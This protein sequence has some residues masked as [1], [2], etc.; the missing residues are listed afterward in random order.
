MNKIPSTVAKRLETAVPKFQK[1]L[2]EA[3]ERDVNESDTVTI[4]KDILQEV[5]GYD[6][7]SEITSEYAIQGTYCDLAVVADKRVEYL[8][9]VKAIGLELNDKHIKQAVNYASGEGIR[10][11]VLTNGIKWE[12]YRVS[13]DK[14]VS[15]EKLFYFDMVEMNPKSKEQQDLLFLLC[16][17]GI[18]KNLIGDYYT[19]KQSVNR[20]T[21]GALLL[22]NKI[23]TAVR[24]ELRKLNPNIKAD[25]EEI[26]S[27]IENEIV[28]REIHE[29]E[30]G[31][32]ANKLIVRFIKKQE[33]ER[34]KA[35]T[36]PAAIEKSSSPTENIDP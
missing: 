33:R 19:Y 9:E 26:K 12:M 6:K 15:S 14:K 21:I 28:K 17:K 7:Y 13:V 30:A 18:K 24:T 11:V 25:I 20:H 27:I 32:E 23:T 16:K 8:I 31:I 3:K 36:T 5:F 10:W 22:T 2:K 35:K 1:I 34:A 4:V 29:S